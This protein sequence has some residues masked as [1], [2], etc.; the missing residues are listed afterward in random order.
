M[1][2]EGGGVVFY[3]DID[4]YF[5]NSNFRFSIDCGV[6]GILCIFCCFI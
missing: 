4:V 3:G 6:I 5:V 2:F 1:R